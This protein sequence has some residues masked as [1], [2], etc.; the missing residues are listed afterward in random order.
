[1]T[2]SREW[3]QRY[4]L[5]GMTS[6]WPWSD[7]VRLFRRHR[8]SREGQVLKVLELGCGSGAN[9]PFFLSEGADYYAIEGSSTIVAE[10][11]RRFPELADK[12]HVADFTEGIPFE[13][14]FD[15][16]VDRSSLTHNDTPSITRTLDDVSL[17]LSEGG[18]MSA[19][20]GSR[21]SIPKCVMASL[22]TEIRIPSMR[23][24]PVCSTRLGECILVARSTCAPCSGSSMY[25]G[26]RERP[27]SSESRM[28]T[29]VT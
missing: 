13:G 7:L 20:T 2:F 1:M 22:S 11:V 27:S 21:A 4:E 19:S 6:L 29:R 16:V 15:V 25:C 26:W 9:I 3:E 14:P 23:S 5:T 18:S 8:R 17:K 10:L 28:R 24:L 12:V